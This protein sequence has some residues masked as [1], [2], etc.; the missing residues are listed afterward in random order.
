[1]KFQIIQTPEEKFRQTAT[2]PLQYCNSLSSFAKPVLFRSA[3]VD[4]IYHDR[5]IKG[6]TLRDLVFYV[7]EA[8]TL[9]TS[10]GNPMTSIHCML[11]G[12]VEIEL[13]GLDRIVINEGEYNILQLSTEEHA[14]ILLPGIY[15]MQRYD[16][17]KRI[18]EADGKPEWLEKLNN[19]ESAIY[20][21]GEVNEQLIKIQTQLKRAVIS[22]EEQEEW[23]Y[24]EMRKY[25]YLVLE[26]QHVAKG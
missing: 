14:I 17:R 9:H 22:T 11:Q 26:Q 1:M 5:S 7:R 6:C 10:I 23:F 24:R 3:P 20:E 4:I 8:V 25:L 15:K 18:I 2:I 19:N 16:Y 13:N 21:H 12:K